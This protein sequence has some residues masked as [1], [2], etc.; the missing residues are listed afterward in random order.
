[1]RGAEPARVRGAHDLA[2]GRRARAQQKKKEEKETE[3]G[4]AAGQALSGGARSARRA[5]SGARRHAQRQLVRAGVVALEARAV[6]NAALGNHLLVI[7]VHGLLAR[8]AFPQRGHGERTTYARREVSVSA[9]ADAPAGGA[10]RR[11]RRGA[12]V[13]RTPR[14]GAD[15]QRRPMLIHFLCTHNAAE[16]LLPLCAAA[17]CVL[18]DFASRRLF[19]VGHHRVQTRP[20]RGARALRRAAGRRAAPQVQR[21]GLAVRA[22]RQRLSRGHLSRPAAHR[23][24]ARARRQGAVRR[25]R[26]HGRG[27]RAR[28]RHACVCHAAPGRALPRRAAPRRAAAPP[29]RSPRSPRTGLLNFKTKYKHGGQEREKRLFAACTYLTEEKLVARSL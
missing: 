5:R 25:S 26:G 23:P 1:M 19:H 21:R 8:R 15:A 6:E 28:N 18:V 12:T 22:R 27:R 14:R 4:T 17:V 11:R 10:L 3:D 13:S 7:R 24:P 16:P 29:R 9:D 2:R 20:G